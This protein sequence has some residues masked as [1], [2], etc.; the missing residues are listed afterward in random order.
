MRKLKTALNKGTIIHM[1]TNNNSISEIWKVLESERTIG[2]VKRLYSNDMEFHVFGTFQYPE[3][4][5]GVA[6]NFSKKLQLDVSPFNNLRELKVMLV[7]DTTF[8]D[9]HL[10]II[11]LL[12]SDNKDVF[13]SLCENLIRSVLKLSGEQKI[14]KT[15]LNQ[16]EKWRN[17]F[18]KNH[19]AGL[20]ATEQ[21]GLFGELH[22]L[23]KALSEL[24]VSPSRLLRTW[25]GVDRELRDYQGNNWALEIKTTSANN[26]QKVIINGERQLDETFFDDLFLF[27]LSVEV[28]NCNGVTLCQKVVEIRE[29][30]ACDLSALNIFNAKLFEAGYLDKHEPLYMEQCYQ[31]RHENYYKIRDDFPRIKESELRTGISEVRYSI[32]LAMCDQYLISQNQ[33]FKTIIEL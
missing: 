19:Y 27:H 11:Q 23:Q 2:L 13:A 29:T 5:Y 21:Q 30:L 25:V 1:R 24:H 20:T 22:F 9:S 6:F 17:L 15:V 32:V 4:Y 28:S 14:V 33:V 7:A 3:K 18:D 12:S 8:P 26:P 10:L 31:I 16:L